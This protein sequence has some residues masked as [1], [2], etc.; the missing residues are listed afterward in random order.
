MYLLEE[1]KCVFSSLS[2]NKQID[3]L[4]TFIAVPLYSAI[5]FYPPHNVDL[6]I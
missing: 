4:L 3:Q 1:G 5:H 2:F 6:N